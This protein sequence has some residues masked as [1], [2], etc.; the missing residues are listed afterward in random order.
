MADRR[1]L[2]EIMDGDADAAA[3]FARRHARFVRAVLGRAERAPRR[4]AAGPGEVVG[5]SA[6][7]D[8]GRALRVEAAAEAFDS[9]FANG[10]RGLRACSDARPIHRALADATRAAAALR[11]LVLPRPADAA[12]PHV[13]PDDAAAA[14]TNAIDRRRASAIKA[15][16]ETCPA[17][18]AAARVPAGDDDALVAAVRATFAARRPARGA[19]RARIVADASGPRLE[20]EERPADDESALPQEEPRRVADDQEPRWRFGTL[21]VAL[22]VGRIAG[23]DVLTA[24]TT[25]SDGAA[26]PGVPLELHAPFAPPIVVAADAAGRAAFPLPTAPAHLALRGADGIDVLL[27]LRP[28]L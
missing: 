21:T 10:C 1:L 17:C 14:A 15:H 3:E 26:A 4:D 16:L 23:I 19:A 8:S 13:H 2:S 7:P 18:A 6:A 20:R 28:A 24:Q 5:A 9:L 12:P 27:D 11:C 25:T 22:A